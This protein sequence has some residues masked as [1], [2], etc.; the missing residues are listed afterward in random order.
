MKI[1]VLII[2]TDICETWPKK[3]TSLLQGPLVTEERVIM[4]SIDINYFRSS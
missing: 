1:L 4:H 2:G 3:Y